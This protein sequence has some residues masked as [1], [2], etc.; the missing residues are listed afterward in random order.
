MVEKKTIPEVP[1]KKKT[2]LENVNKKKSKAEIYDE[3]KEKKKEKFTLTSFKNRF[4]RNLCNEG[5]DSEERPNDK[6][7][8]KEVKKRLQGKRLDF[9]SLSAYKR[10]KIQEVKKRGEEDNDSLDAYYTF[11]SNRP[12]SPW[13]LL[14]DNGTKDGGIFE[15][16]RD[17]GSPYFRDAQKIGEE[18]LE[19]LR[20]VIGC[21]LKSLNRLAQLLGPTKAGL[22]VEK[23]E[24]EILKPTKTMSK[25][26]KETFRS[27]RFFDP[28]N[29]SESLRLPLHQKKQSL[30]VL[31]TQRQHLGRLDDKIST[32]EKGSHL[33]NTLRSAG[34]VQSYANGCKGGKKKKKKNL[35]PK[36]NLKKEIEIRETVLAEE[37]E[38]LEKKEK[39]LLEVQRLL[40][41]VHDKRSL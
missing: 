22:G 19:A 38:K 36:L 17:F 34:V 26:S 31:C 20:S 41:S 15:K 11:I 5:S 14:P 8:E 29:P 23:N 7:K 6:S 3:K 21:D 4:F 27:R 25:V 32:Y 12:S 9:M 30:D 1:N 10:K 40:R 39:K 13:E 18:S 33:S 16:S 24:N 2:A 35:Y 28:E 37:Y